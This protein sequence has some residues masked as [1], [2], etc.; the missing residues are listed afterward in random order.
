MMIVTD[1]GGCEDDSDIC[2]GCG[3]DQG[4]RSRGQTKVIR[5][6]SI[7]SPKFSNNLTS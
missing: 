7:I 1:G 6:G 3:V 5:N 4:T 2:R